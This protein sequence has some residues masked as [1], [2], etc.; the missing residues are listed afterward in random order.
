MDIELTTEQIRNF[1]RALLAAFDRG[2]MQR[3]VRLGLNKTYANIVPSGAL[4]DEFMALVEWVNKQNKVDALLTEARKQN[5]GNIQLR[6]F[7]A[8]LRGQLP[9]PLA[10]PSEHIE[11]IVA[12]YR[13][14][15]ES[16]DEA[17]LASQIRQYL[18][19]IIDRYGKIVMRGVE[20]RG[21]NV[22]NL[23]LDQ[24]YVPLQAQTRRAGAQQQIDI[25]LDQLLPLAPQ[26]II[27]GG[28]GSGKTTV[29]Q[30]I[31]W[32]LA[33]GLTQDP[34]LAARALGLD[35]LSELS[36]PLPLYLPLSRY[37]SY[38]RELRQQGGV[39]APHKVTL[40]SF[41]SHYLIERSTVLRLP[42]DFFVRLI[43]NSQALIL[44]L[45]GL[46]E[47]PDDTERSGI[48][49]A[50]EDLVAGRPGLRTLVT[51]R[52][53]AYQGQ[54]LLNAKFHQVQVKPLAEAQVEQLVMQ[55]FACI[56]PVDT[57]TREQN[58]KKLND[59]IRA[60]EAERA[61]RM[62]AGYKRLID[63]P[64]MVRMLLLVFLTG[65]GFPEQRADLY[66]K[67][68]R[69]LLQPDY[70]LDDEAAQEIGRLVGGDPGLHR[71]L[72]E[73]LAFH[74]HQAGSSQSRDL[75]EDE[76]ER[77]IRQE[78]DLARLAGPFVALT[79]VRGGLVEERWGAYRFFHLA[80]QEYLTASY[81]VKTRL[82]EGGVDRIAAFLEQ[83]PLL[84]SWWRE[85]AL[86][87]AGYFAS[88]GDRINDRRFVCR[89]A[90]IGRPPDQTAA[91]SADI[92]L[93]A[94]EI[95]LLSCLEWLG[96][97]VDL[98]QKLAQWAAGILNNRA[99]MTQ[100]T[101]R[102]RAAAGN[103][104]SRLGD[105]R[106][107]VG[108][109]TDGLPDI[110]WMP[111]EAGEFPMGSNA[112]S[113]D[114][115]PIHSVDLDAFAIAKYPITN[116]QYACFVAA[117]GREPPKHWG[118][119]TPP[120]ELHTHPVRNVSWKNAAAFCD[121]LSEESGMAIRLPTEA[122]WEKAA[123]GTDG[124]TYPWGNE[125]D[126]IQTLCNMNGTGIEG[127]SPVGIFPAGESPYKVAEMA[128]NVREWVND[129]YDKDYYRVSPRDNP[130]GPE[131]GEYRVL[132]GGSWINSGS[133]VRSANRYNNF[134]DNWNVN[135]GCRCVRSL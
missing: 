121:W 55:A 2:E 74:M 37:H 128:G 27:T 59:G 117:T 18:A 69:T 45:D 46:D 127:T 36:L 118:G 71:K 134:P 64:L 39:D 95:A 102:V 7:E 38:R 20:Y 97:D 57:S 19:W 29:L 108:V 23:D 68:T 52:T 110:A 58:I 89:L 10:L 33:M 22:I 87:I 17:D 82:G 106:P 40:H 81:L 116:S 90:G 13:K 60:F 62:G 84:E 30:H 126:K 26:L 124:R 78:N 85:P 51:C 50:V 107:G 119:R 24:V 6:N 44:L 91:L 15:N 9:P 93:A 122:E 67:A 35:A 111:V 132:R 63:S 8:A 131:R 83:G 61:A 103:A 34:A 130:Q 28:P 54:T 112:A 99:L 75:S 65:R 113:D 96:T 86:L 42:P 43:E 48:C 114:E 101:P 120:D 104:L 53:A 12:F 49:A 25:R 1:Q 47:V 125:S 72:V 105:P 92:Q 115:K 32:S 135:D 77:I 4:E 123:R 66:E 79:R 94:V 76:L 70:G 88:T 98:R 21:R 16:L 133:Y 14:P 80:F 5:P 129:W 109:G 11:K 41:L 31:A 3:V 73:H 100:S 56:E